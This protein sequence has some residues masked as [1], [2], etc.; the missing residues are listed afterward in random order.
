MLL[1]AVLIIM[2]TLLWIFWRLLLLLNNTNVE[3]DNHYQATW[4]SL[5]VD[6]MIKAR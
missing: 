2:F 1:F 6:S 5:L 4:I 3:N